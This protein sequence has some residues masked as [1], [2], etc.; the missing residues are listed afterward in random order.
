MY[1]T[2][3]AFLN[4]TPWGRWGRELEKKE[5]WLSETELDLDPIHE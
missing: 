1:H 5:N 3:L 4:E 2:K